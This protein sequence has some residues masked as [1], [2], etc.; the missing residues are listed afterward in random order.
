MPGLFDAQTVFHMN[1][2][3]A[4]LADTQ[5]HVNQIFG[6]AYFSNLFWQITPVYWHFII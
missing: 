6:I 1:G 3:P 2:Q 4:I 5:R